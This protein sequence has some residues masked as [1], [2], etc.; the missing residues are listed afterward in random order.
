MERESLFEPFSIVVK[1]LDECPKDEHEHTFF[2]FVYILSGTGSHSINKNTFN[3]SQGDLFLISPASCHSFNIYTT[4]QFFFL[5]FNNIYIESK[6]IGVSN[7][8][9]LEQILCNANHLSGCILKYQEDKSLVKSIID[10]IVGEFVNND[11]YARELIEQLVNTLIIIVARN[12]AQNLPEILTDSTD[13]KIIGIIQYIHKN[14][15]YPENISSEKIGNHFNIS[16]N[17]LGRYFKKHTSETLQH[18]TANYKIK[19]IESRLKYSQMR[20]SE[21]SSEFR[22]NDDSHFNKF[23]KTQKGIS[24]SEFRKAHKA[25]L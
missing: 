11:L 7:I 16:I 2:E 19:L 21:I 24:P 5:R 18:Y 3:Y 14:I 6:P 22:F 23:F 4:T 9:R 13:E 15:F 12:I 20:L 1:T 25:V 10:A 17:Y 8:Q